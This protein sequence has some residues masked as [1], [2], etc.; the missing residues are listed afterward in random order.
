MFKN[1][2]LAI[3]IIALSG[4]VATENSTATSNAQL[5][6][7]NSSITNL[8]QSLSKQIVESCNQDNQQLIAELKAAINT[9][10][11]GNSLP[12]DKEVVYVE[13]CSV[14]NK[15][16]NP[17]GMILIGEVENIFLVKEKTT[18]A[19]RIDTGADTSSL[20][21][22]NI[23]KFERDGKKW[24]KFSL[25]GDKDSKIFEYA[26]YDTVKIKQQS[27]MKAEE[28]IEIKLAIKVGKKEYR[29]QIFNLADRSHL[30]FQVLIGRNFLKDIAL[31]DVS[32]KHLLGGE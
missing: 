15:Q 16:A 26:I 20:G 32:K 5:E 17:S 4:C 12:A 24:V 18:F 13:R 22:Y 9:N 23:T 31:V 11:N 28:R 27:N 10:E 6:Q 7:V 30:E 21:V 25:Q 19:A 29:G 14:K 1:I 2:M 8:E 3:S